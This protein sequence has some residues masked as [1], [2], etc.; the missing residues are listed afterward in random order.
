MDLVILINDER[1]GGYEYNRSYFTNIHLWAL[2]HCE[3]YV[4]M[5]IQDVSD[6]SLQWDEIAAY[7]FGQEKDALLFKLKWQ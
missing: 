5:N 1:S 7:E 4:G 2:E 6:V 3:S